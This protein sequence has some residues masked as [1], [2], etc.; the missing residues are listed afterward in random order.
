MNRAARVVM[1][2]KEISNGSSLFI[3]LYKQL[4]DSLGDTHPCSVSG[5]GA[6]LAPVSCGE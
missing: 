5:K 4:D 6:S 2:V 3:Q 1:A